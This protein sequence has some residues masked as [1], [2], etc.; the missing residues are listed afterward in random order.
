[1]ENSKSLLDKIVEKF[2]DLGFLGNVE[3]EKIIV[4]DE[5]ENKELKKSENENKENYI[6]KNIYIISPN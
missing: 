2:N 5:I 3:T 4:K 1:M 6:S